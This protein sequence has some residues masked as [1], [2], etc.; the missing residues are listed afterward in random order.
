[1]RVT[2]IQSDWVGRV[3]GGQFSLVQ[4]LGGTGHSG[5]FLTELAG[6]PSQK[7]AIKLMPDDAGAEARIACATDASRANAHLVRVVQGG[8][9]EIDGSPFVYFVTEYA[10]EV[11]SE[12]LPVRPLTPEEVK[13][14]L[15]PVLDTLSDLHAL[16]LVHGHLRPSNILVVNDQ[17]KLS[18]D[19][20]QP[21][22][23]TSAE[24]AQLSIH[25]APERTDGTVAPASDMWSL[26]VTIVEAL[27]QETPEWSRAANADPLIPGSIPQP[28]AGIAAACLRVDPARRATV[29]DVRRQLGLAV[30]V[31]A[32]PTRPEPA[33]QVEPGSAGKPGVVVLAVVAVLFAVVIALFWWHSRTPQPAPQS[34]DEP[35][36]QSHAQTASATAPLQPSAAPAPSPSARASAPVQGGGVAVK[37]VVAHRAMP[38]V[39]PAAYDS[40]RGTVN[41][42][43]RLSVSPAGEVT[44]ANFE[45]EGPSKYFAKVA[46]EAARKWK[47]VPARADGQ[48]VA[49]NWILQFAFTRGNTDIN[50][51]QTSP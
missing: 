22:N 24:T 1:M 48:P 26:G 29:N 37:G 6:A 21:A 3:I 18:A 2:S 7:A 40:I 23:S 30:P 9:C 44:D 34:S 13:E 33:T 14:M 39:L 43:V 12:I 27:T 41:V 46:M 19:S 5:V 28:F 31:A 49:S 25:D 45:S 32:P 17:L 47:F 20:V 35:S 11:L 42:R 4:W 8:R 50:A 36:S 10:D 16:G 15:V 51:E 38:D